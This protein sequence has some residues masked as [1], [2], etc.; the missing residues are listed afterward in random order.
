MNRKTYLSECSTNPCLDKPIQEI[1]PELQ[2][3]YTN[4]KTDIFY[5]LKNG[6]CHQTFT[7][8]YCKPWEYVRFWKTDPVP[9]CFQEK[10]VIGCRGVGPTTGRPCPQGYKRVGDDCVPIADWE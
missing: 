6:T 9:S 7:Q 5:F 1:S 4:A 8:A 2:G 3:A 10:S